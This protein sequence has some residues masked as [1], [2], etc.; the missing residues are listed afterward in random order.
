M[1]FNF[2]LFQRHSLVCPLDMYLPNSRRCSTSSKEIMHAW[3]LKKLMPKITFSSFSGPQKYYFL[4][5]H[6]NIILYLVKNIAWKSEIIY[7]G[8]GTFQE[9]AVHT[10]MLKSTL[11]SNNGYTATLDP[12]HEWHPNLNNNTH[13]SF[14]SHSC[15]NP[16]VLK[17]EW[18]AKDV[19]S[20]V[21][22]I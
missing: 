8:E 2:Q 9:P 17:H 19:P 12:L 4:R 7:I 16:F 5:K 11:S 3:C 15:K 21:I 6:R 22:Q 18:E 20:I 13:R 10:Y 1:N 14:A